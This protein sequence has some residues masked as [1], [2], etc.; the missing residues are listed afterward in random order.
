VFTKSPD[1]F[2]S[3]LSLG[4]NANS[5]L[6]EL[7]DRGM[8]TAFSIL[9]AFRMGSRVVGLGAVVFVMTLS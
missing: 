1:L 5:S 4:R 3:T 8:D 2:S 7:Y 6:D 9:V